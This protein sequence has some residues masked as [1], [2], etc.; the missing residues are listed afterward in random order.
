V[1][2]SL[3]ASEKNPPLQN[4]YT[5]DGGAAYGDLPVVLQ[6]QEEA[7]LSEYL[8]Q[9]EHARRVKGRTTSTRKSA[10]RKGGKTRRE[11][12]TPPMTW[13]RGRICSLVYGD[14]TPMG[15]RP[16]NEKKEL[17]ERWNLDWSLTKLSNY[18]LADHFAYLATRY[19]FGNGDAKDDLTLVM[20]DIDVLKSLGRGSPAGALA[21]AEHLKR[22]RWPDLYHEPS[23]GGSGVHGYLVLRK[24]G[25][26]AAEVNDALR[27]LERWLKAEAVRVNADIEL[28][29]VKGACLEVTF[30]KGM[31]ESAK[32]GSFAK[33]PRD[34][35]RFAE[36]EAT[37]ILSMAE[38]AGTGYD[39]RAEAEVVAAPLPPHP[40][41]AP[42]AKA[43]RP[44][45]GSVSGK[46]VSD[47]DLACLPRYA[48]LFRP[49]TDGKKLKAGKFAVTA[50][51]FAIACLLLRF[52]KK[53]PNRDGSLPTER[54]KELWA[55]LYTAGD[56]HRAWS[57]H[58]WKAIR[59]LL[60][61]K[62]H[63][64]WTD[65]RYEYGQ[66]VNGV[67]VA[68]VACKFEIT[69]EF[70]DLLDTVAEVGAVVATSTGGASFMD[71]P[72]SRSLPKQGRG[73]FLVPERFPIRA[74]NERFFW[75]SA[76]E[77]CDTLCAA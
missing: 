34:V 10:K 70:A 50:E 32:Y 41:Q 63:I 55:G 69:G 43:K 20:I 24:L 33:L 52:F 65:H 9:R 51:D 22:T 11:K 38:L 40:P 12:T 39:V 66:V 60:S 23:T 71:T 28:V 1:Y 64:H 31:M 21:F 54:A 75:K 17:I 57:H 47:E 3:L 48:A 6:L 76:F 67:F 26:G 36:W 77:V 56:V 45:P 44:I 5:L 19:F 25:H 74:E 16:S 27:R 13:L 73:R 29:E 58:R 46:L 15:V 30:N 61:S 14:L 18:K 62:G 4:V 7:R 49:M 53:N 37:T 59:D 68:G 2:Y 42:R 72:V 8:A 35:G